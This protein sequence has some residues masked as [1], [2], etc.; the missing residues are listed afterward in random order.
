M[1]FEDLTPCTYFG[2]DTALVAVGW[3]E[4]GRPFY[5]GEVDAAVYSALVEMCHRPWQPVVFGG[6]HK[7]DLCQFDGRS[8]AANLFIPHEGVLYACPALVVH[9]IDAHWYCPPEP[10]RRAVLACP[11]MHSMAYLRA[12]A[13]AGGA[14]LGRPPSR[15]PSTHRGDEPEK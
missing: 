3:L 8:G 5:V 9:Y 12:I 2:L 1:W 11:P 14:R 7:C 15:A 13:A 4:R 10:F 6:A